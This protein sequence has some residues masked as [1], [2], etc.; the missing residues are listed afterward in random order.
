MDMTKRYKDFSG[1]KCDII[2]MVKREPEWAATRVQ[3]GELA[4]EQLEKAKEL[5]TDIQLM[6]IQH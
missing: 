3:M 5:L 1:N 2:E 6:E 4:I